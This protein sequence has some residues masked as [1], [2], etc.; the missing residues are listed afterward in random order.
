PMT[1]D[2]FMSGSTF[3]NSLNFE[4]D[5]FAEAS[6]RRVRR[7][8]MMPLRVVLLSSFLFS[9]IL[10]LAL[11]NLREVSISFEGAIWYR[12]ESWSETSTAGRYSSS[13]WY[14]STSL[15]Y[16]LK[17]VRPDRR[18]AL[19]SVIN[20]QRSSGESPLFQ[21]RSNSSFPLYWTT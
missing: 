16:S 12:N 14:F 19:A 9:K 4:P 6:S 13:F 20:P 1:N 10:R 21:T 15:M 18:K 5:V 2:R 8:A 3:A 11:W 17:D 7:A